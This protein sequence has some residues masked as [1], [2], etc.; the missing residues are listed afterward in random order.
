MFGAEHRR[1]VARNYILRNYDPKITGAL[2]SSAGDY[3]GA[4]RSLAGVGNQAYVDQ[5]QFGRQGRSVFGSGFLPALVDW[6]KQ[7]ASAEGAGRGILPRGTAEFAGGGSVLGF[8][9]LS[10]G[11]GSG[12]IRA[13]MHERVLNPA[14][15]MT[16]G[17]MIDAHKAGRDSSA[18]SMRAPAQSNREVHL[19]VHALDLSDFKGYLGRGG[20]EAI[21]AS[22]NSYDGEY[23][24]NADMS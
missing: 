16:Y 10:L 11:D 13:H 2:L 7:L 3:E 17:P 21:R 6:E 4:Q 8:G 14:D 23:A 19:H 12:L 9:P 1:N 22:L 20:A 15:S 18:S 24:G 5:K